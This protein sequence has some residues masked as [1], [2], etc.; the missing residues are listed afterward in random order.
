MLS[1][2]AGDRAYMNLRWGLGQRDLPQ[3]ALM[4]TALQNQAQVDQCLAETTRL[5]LPPCGYAV[6]N[7]DTLAAVREVL[8]RTTPGA[9]VL[10]AGA[11]L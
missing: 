1:T 8:Q 6:K 11:E 5:R 3:A 7:W 10:D 2:N 4:N 9:R